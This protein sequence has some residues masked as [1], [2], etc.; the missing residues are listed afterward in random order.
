LAAHATLIERIVADGKSSLRFDIVD[1][2]DGNLGEVTVNDGPIAAVK[3]ALEAEKTR[4][5][6][7]PVGTTIDL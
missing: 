3:A 6:A 1:D 2:T 5:M 4:L 7:L